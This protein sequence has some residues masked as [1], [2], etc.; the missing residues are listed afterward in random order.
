MTQKIEGVKEATKNK[1]GDKMAPMIFHG[2]LT[3]GNLP[4][5][6]KSTS[7]LLDEARVLLAGGTG[8]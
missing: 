6:E 2:L 5:S 4:E 8:R 1:T 3:N 7:R